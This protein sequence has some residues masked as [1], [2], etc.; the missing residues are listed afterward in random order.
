M[1]GDPVTYALVDTRRIVIDRDGNRCIRCGRKREEIH[2]RYRR[3][4]GGSTHPMIHAPTNLVCLCRDCHR[5]AE[6]QR[7]HANEHLGL[8]IPTLGAAASTPVLTGD[9]WKL[10]TIGGTWLLV[11][12]TYQAPNVD[13]ARLVAF[14]YGLIGGTDDHL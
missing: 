7:R 6:S 1:R 4:M 5:S 9:G 12:P 13:A 11:C 2:H 10:P 3:G 8:C 14:H